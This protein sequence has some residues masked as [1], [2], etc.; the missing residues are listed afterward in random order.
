M[1]SKSKCLFFI[2]IYWDLFVHASTIRRDLTILNSRL[3]FAFKKYNGNKKS[4]DGW[5]Q[6]EAWDHGCLCLGAHPPSLHRFR[7][8]WRRA[9]SQEL[10]HTATQTRA[11]SWKLSPASNTVPVK[12]S[13]Q[14]TSIPQRTHFEGYADDQSDHFDL[15]C[16]PCS[17][18]YPTIWHFI[19]QIMWFPFFENGQHRKLEK[20][21]KRTSSIISSLLTI[22]VRLS[23]IDC[24]SSLWSSC[25]YNVSSFL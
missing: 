20:M 19:I 8:P 25:D 4:Q 12:L 23:P 6:T 7:H 24:F 2:V 11:V 1:H 15:L 17:L 10:R 21:V 14:K 16:K 18:W 3:I 13:S 22:A 9:S 5:C